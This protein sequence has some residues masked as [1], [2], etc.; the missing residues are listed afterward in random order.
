MIPVPASSFR[1]SGVFARS[2][3]PGTRSFVAATAGLLIGAL[4][5]T[6]LA[7]KAWAQTPAATAAPVAVQQEQVNWMAALL[8]VTFGALRRESV[9][10]PEIVVKG[11]ALFDVSPHFQI[12]PAIGASVNV[13]EG[14]VQGVAEVEFNFTFIHGG[15]VGG[16]VGWWDFNDSARDDWTVLAHAGLPL[17]RNIH[18]QAKL[19]LVIE[20]RL[21]GGQFDNI[22]NNYQYG[23]GFRW[24]FR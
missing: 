20:G 9:T 7:S 11:G 8:Q 19:L 6:A 23:A 16:G 3:E 13:D 5:L 4:A 15:Y 21:F 14:G 10:D 1:V 18:K 12:A 22:S 17:T 2:P 24:A